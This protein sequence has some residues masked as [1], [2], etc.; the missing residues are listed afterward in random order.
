MIRRF[1]FVMGWLTI[2]GS[3]GLIRPPHGNT[4]SPGGF[5]EEP[6]EVPVDIH[7]LFNVYDRVYFSSALTNAGVEIKWG[8]KMMT[9]C[10][11]MCEYKGRTG[12]IQIRLSPSL[13]QYRSND[14]VKDTLLHEMIHA[15][16]FLDHTETDRDGHGVHF[17]R[18]MDRI[19]S[20]RNPSDPY[21]PFGGYRIT[22]FH[23]FINEVRHFQT[24]MW[25]C[26]KCHHV[27]RRAM[28]RPP[29]EKDCRAYR[30]DLSGWTL[31]KDSPRNRCGDRRCY[32]H[33]HIRMCGGAY[34]RLTPEPPAKK[35][36]RESNT[37][38]NLQ[39]ESLPVKT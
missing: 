5:F 27:I 38:R 2:I 8:S 20:I 11:G 12:S 9:K 22:V 26:E 31:S 10:A 28:N 29:S 25:K 34:K 30:K 16:L 15:Y 17:H 3:A 4:F 21:R 1:L 14:D 36:K 13:L 35:K 24:H 39:K 6:V 37:S 19:N 33:N 7:D 18:H 23:S 32:V